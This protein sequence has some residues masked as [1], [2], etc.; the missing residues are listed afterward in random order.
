MNKP[1]PKYVVR[2]PGFEHGVNKPHIAKRF[3]FTYA[4]K[5]TGDDEYLWM[6]LYDDE[7]FS[8]N[9]EA[10]LSVYSSLTNRR[11]MVL[12]GLLP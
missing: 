4:F 2:K 1:Y 10:K 5:K 11:N 7:R 6:V 3:G 12:R 8:P 9:L